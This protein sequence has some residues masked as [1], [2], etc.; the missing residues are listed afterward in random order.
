MTQLLKGARERV[1]RIARDAIFR[2]TFWMTGINLVASVA[3]YLW[4]VYA[5]RNMDPG[6]YGLLNALLASTILVSLLGDVLRQWALKS[7]TELA[8]H[9]R[10]GGLM[11]TA[12]FFSIRIAWAALFLVAF[13]LGSTLLFPG[14]FKIQNLSHGLLFSGLVF[15]T[16]ALILPGVFLDAFQNFRIHALGNFFS[17]MFRLGLLA[18]ILVQGMTLAKVLAVHLLSVV[19]QGLYVFGVAWWVLRKI[20]DRAESA[21]QT[22]SSQDLPYFFKIALSSVFLTLLMN[23]DMALARI[24][25]SPQASGEYATLSIFGRAVFYAST[26]ALPVFFV[27]VSDR[28]HRK[29]P[30]GE[31]FFKSLAGIGG[32]A[33]LGMIGLVIF[34]KPF[35]SVLN[36][37]YHHLIPEILMFAAGGLSYVFINFFSLFYVS[38][39]RYR[40]F[41]PLIG[42]A[43]LQAAL[44]L[45]LGKTIHDF[46]LLRSMTG[47]LLLACMLGYFFYKR[48]RFYPTDGDLKSGK[49]PHG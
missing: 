47:A 11:A 48:G 37:A 40:V 13:A 19:F 16:F 24:A 28:F 42:L 3:N 21:G 2:D 36:P 29:Q 31:A 15:L 38:V 27:S 30:Y 20:P 6:D 25:L 34:L 39:N 8:S 12:R 10:H 1:G 41:V 18:L 49:N 33:L 23:Q 46:V 4:Q 9:K 32:V 7:F 22:P 17:S 5:N 43:L 35:L 14:L 26:A 45:F 44:F